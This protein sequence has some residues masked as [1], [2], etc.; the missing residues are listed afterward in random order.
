MPRQSRLALALSLWAMLL[1]TS[2]AGAG[3]VSD[4]QIQKSIDRAVVYLRGK[5]P[6]LT[7][8]HSA[9]VTMALLKRGL[10]AETPE[11]KAAI[12]KIKKQQ[13]A[14]DGAYTPG[15][16][17][18]YEAGVSLMALA[19][20]DPQQY[21]PQIAA[22]AK[23]LIS[24]QRPDG[25]WDYPNPMEGDTSITQY[26]I[27]GLWE[28]VRAGVE[29]P[30]RVWDKAGGWH[31]TRQ[32]TDGSF[33]YHP[34]KLGFQAAGSH[35]MTVAGTAS[36][37]V[38]RLHLYPGA[39]DPD[40]NR[41]AGKK[42]RRGKKYGILI[43]GTAEVDE[44]P[45]P[46]AAD[47]PYKVTTRLSAIDKSIGKGKDWLEE[48]FT[49]EPK[50]S[51]DMYYLYGLERFAALADVKT[52]DGHDWYAEGAAHLISTQSSDGTW[53][54]GCGIE[55]ATAFGVLF[56]TKATQKMLET[57]QRV[58][59]P[60]YGGGLLVGG[61]GLPDDLEAV[62]L[63]QGEVRVRK[64]KGPVD[65]LLAELENAQSRQVESA[66]EALVDTII[67]EDPEALVGQSERLL[68]L[69]TDRRAE[70]RRTAFWALGR[71][72]NL[73]VVPVLIKGLNDPEPSCVV[74]A[75]NALKFISKKMDQNEPPDEPSDEQ[76]ASAV[77]FWTKWYRAVRPYDERD[78]LVESSPVAK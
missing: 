60:K 23:Y 13:F 17:H 8:G 22:I 54:D 50:G 40:A 74:E 29:V 35:S 15:A 49:V 21:K 70:V 53:R 20:A 37:H 55:A 30:R 72:N 66:Q 58:R 56:L 19:N 41:V 7:D 16:H 5:L 11:I 42:K 32:L 28:A 64:L 71:T 46:D 75:R 4:A 57:R 14:A 2:P 52:I 34:S 47:A 9:L 68:K 73:R 77:A 44:G 62:Q 59:T 65:E 76:R 43:P 78:D 10:S 69:A 24:V 31:V 45:S 48:K 61:R 33:T 36:L 18:V 25:E 6:G 67:N 51:W 26:G 38:V 63:D 12:D 3:Q 1:A 27:L 39:T